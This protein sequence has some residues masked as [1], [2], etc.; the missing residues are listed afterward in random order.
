MYLFAELKSKMATIVRPRLII[1]NIKVHHFSINMHTT[2]ICYTTV[3]FL[4]HVSIMFMKISL[5]AT[6]KK[7]FPDLYNIKMIT[8]KNNNTFGVEMSCYLYH[9]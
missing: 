7:C 9:I 5:Y 1:G 8:E 4:V 2:N 6:K 3:N